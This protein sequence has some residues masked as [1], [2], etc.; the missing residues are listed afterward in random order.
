[1][2]K[3]FAVC[4]LSASVGCTDAP[5]VESLV[6]EANCGS[7]CC[8]MCSDDHNGDVYHPIKKITARRKGGALSM[9]GL[10]V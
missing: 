1:M 6:Y 10:L 2:K 8:L 5:K 7:V 3:I 4:L 9:F